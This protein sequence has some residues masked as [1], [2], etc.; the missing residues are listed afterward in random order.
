MIEYV[1]FANEGD[2]EE[3]LYLSAKDQCWDKETLK[4]LKDKYHIF[5]MTT[6]DSC[7]PVMVVPAHGGHFQ[8]VFGVEDDGTVSFTKKY[9]QWQNSIYDFWIPTFIDDLEAAMS[10]V[11]DF[12]ATGAT[13]DWKPEEWERESR[14]ER[15]RI[16]TDE[17][18]D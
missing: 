3:T 8:Y 12:K 15:A 1:I 2:R 17:E 14:E 11:K 13:A 16:K 6:G 18:G 7:H 4:E 9:G 10:F 5:F